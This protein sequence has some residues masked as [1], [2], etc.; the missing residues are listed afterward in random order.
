MNSSINSLN[1]FD[2]L[3]K[4]GRQLREQAA[5][6]RKRIDDA[7]KRRVNEPLRRARE[8][9]EQAF[10]NRFGKPL[11]TFY[12]FVVAGRSDFLTDVY[13]KLAQNQISK[14]KNRVLNAAEIGRLLRMDV[15]PQVIKIPVKETF[16]QLCHNN[17]TF[18]CMD[19]LDVTVTP[20]SMTIGDV[21]LDISEVGR[22]N[23]IESKHMLE[24]KIKTVVVI[25]STCSVRAETRDGLASAVFETPVTSS[26]ELHIHVTPKVDA[27]FEGGLAVDV[28]IKPAQIKIKM[29]S[30]KISAGIS[31]VVSSNI[32][33]LPKCPNNGFLAG[34]EVPGLGA[35][36]CTANAFQTCTDY[37]GYV[38]GGT[39]LC[40]NDT[41]LSAVLM[42]KIL[43]V[44]QNFSVPFF[45]PSDVVQNLIQEKMHKAIA[46]EAVPMAAK[47]F[48]SQG[49]ARAF[50]DN[51]KGFPISRSIRFLGKELEV[52]FDVITR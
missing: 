10:N 50:L 11:K 25:P 42:Q 24:T 2:N 26:C 5:A 35:G 9:A 48:R 4:L 18:K 43:R 36:Y 7:V 46:K 38:S 45:P 30:I 33:K 51:V 31:R 23:W 13:K 20:I 22:Q 6:E 21:Q 29:E 1:F 19:T 34:Y 27:R 8:R 32:K 39:G 37:A 14:F 41:I 49:A 52:R 3:G 28:I 16:T 44:Y 12:K 17:S 40:R 15:G 47:F